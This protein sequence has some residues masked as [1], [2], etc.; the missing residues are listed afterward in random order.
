[1][2]ERESKPRD[3]DANAREFLKIFRHGMFPQDHPQSLL[4]DLD[5]IYRSL[6]VKDNIAI[7]LDRGP[8]AGLQISF[9]AEQTTPTLIC[10]L[11]H[12]AISTNLRPAKNEI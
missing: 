10:E 11:S 9:L 7:K 6:L 4:I 2:K 3:V 12:G 8:G 1:M 5:F